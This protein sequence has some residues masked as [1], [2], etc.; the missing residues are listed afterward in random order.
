MHVTNV[1]LW[2]SFGCMYGQAGTAAAMFVPAAAADN[3][4]L[5]VSYSDCLS[6]HFWVAC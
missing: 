5:V 1:T 3:C 6:V 4:F 2:F